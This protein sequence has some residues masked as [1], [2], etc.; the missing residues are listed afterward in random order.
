MDDAGHAQF[1]AWASDWITRR[2]DSEVARAS[3]EVTG[4]V[5]SAMFTPWD[6][7]WFGLAIATAFKLGSGMLSEE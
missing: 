6:L 5:F 7:L 4:E 2:V 3:E 1:A